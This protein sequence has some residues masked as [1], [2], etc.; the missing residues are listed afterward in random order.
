MC[1]IGAVVKWAYHIHYNVSGVLEQLK[2]MNGKLAGV[3]Q[4]GQ[5]IE[6]RLSIAEHDIKEM[7]HV[8]RE[9][10]EGALGVAEV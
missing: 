1:S 6:V 5:Q 4:T 8:F 7:K 9:P 2:A 3:T 10:V